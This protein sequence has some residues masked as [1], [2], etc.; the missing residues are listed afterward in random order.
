MKRKLI[1]QGIG[2]LTLYIPK[3]WANRKGLKEGDEIEIIEKET[4]L[5]L[6]SPVKTQ[7]ETIIEI[8]DKNK[9][10]IFVLLTHYYRQ[11]FDKIIIENSSQIIN[12]DIK[13]RIN[14]ILLGFEITEKTKDKIVIENLSE[15]T[16]QKID[17]IL[18][19]LFLITKETLNMLL[20]ENE[21]N[22]EELQ[23]MKLNHDRFILFCKR[24]ITKE[25]EEK[26]PALSW[27]LLTFLQHIQHTAHYLHMHI[28]R[29]KIKNQR[30]PLRIINHLISY[31]SSFSKAYFEKDIDEIHK[32]N[33]LKEKYQLGECLVLLSKSRK[34]ET[35]M[36]S[37][38]REI[39]RL[40]QIG[41]S[42]ILAEI[43]EKKFIDIDHTF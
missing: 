21:K 12:N 13:N 34:E 25:Y 1:R 23:E 11:G 17:L 7:K 41:T 9:R 28:I 16:D 5:L 14:S 8:N 36:H 20:E 30:K 39:F 37:Y 32:I 26:N 19:R 4:S 38:I 2:G 24:I 35:I 42:P 6:Q 18:R 29:S 10:D 27:E 40:I 43:I 3:K 33:D 31:F 22:K 15:P